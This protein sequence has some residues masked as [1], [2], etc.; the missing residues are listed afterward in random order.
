MRNVLILCTGTKNAK[1]LHRQISAKI[2]FHCSKKLPKAIGRA[3]S[4]FS[5]SFDRLKKYSIATKIGGFQIS[6]FSSKSLLFLYRSWYILFSK[7]Q[8]REKKRQSL[9]LG[10]VV[11]KMCSEGLGSLNCTWGTNWT[12]LSPHKSIFEPI[13]A[14][15][16]TRVSLSLFSQFCKF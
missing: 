4:Q 13:L 7:F 11:E 2:Q 16:T 5:P 1:T 15:K 12:V 10:K 9:I 14:G 6:W 8:K 3:R